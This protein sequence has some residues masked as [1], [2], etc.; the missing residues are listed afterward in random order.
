MVVSCTRET[1]TWLWQG[2]PIAYQQA[3]VNQ[4]GKPI[5]VLIHGFGAS[6]GHWRQN[7]E[8]LA[9]VAQVYALD[10][11][12][13]GQS[14]K[15]TPNRRGELLPGEQ[16]PYTFET[17]GAQVVD[18]CREVAQG[19]AEQPVLLIGNSIGCIVAMQ[20][21]VQAPELVKAVALLNCSLRL[22]HERKRATLPWYR[23]V[24]ASAM[25]GL[26]SFAPFGRFFFSQV[27][28]RNTVRKILLKAYSR[29]ET[30]SDELV[31]L[32]LEPAASSGAAEVFLA[33]VRYSQGPLP[34]DLLAVLPCPAL[35][36]WGEHDPWEPVQ[37][38]RELA[39]FDCVQEF[40][41][42]PAGHCPQDE[43]PDLVN[44][45]LQSWIQQ[46]A[47]AGVQAN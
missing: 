13:F 3:G 30:V 19:T 7:L 15:P 24:G 37:L 27:S 11:I 20:A 29:P 23:G 17:W 42:V 22:L 25:Q 16:V 45:L 6:S 40:V 44:P 36:I 43:A 32:L 8:A 14:A 31:E 38:G 12:G 39:R 47:S 26:L 46:Y 4:P 18:F 2:F 41:T 34:E 5:V 33:F 28:T 1:L 35:M 21:A 10:L 9:T